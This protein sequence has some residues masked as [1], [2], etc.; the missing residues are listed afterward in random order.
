[1]SPISFSDKP[2]EFRGYRAAVSTRR[3]PAAFNAVPISW[4]LLLCVKAA[5]IEAHPKMTCGED[6]TTLNEEWED[7]G[8][9]QKKKHFKK[10]RT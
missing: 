7:V 5:P 8:V 6:T 4:I 10:D 9:K 3:I 1:M 2:G